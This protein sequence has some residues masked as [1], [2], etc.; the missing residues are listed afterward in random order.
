MIG[1]LAVAFIISDNI[2]SYPFLHQLG[3]QFLGVL[4]CAIWAFGVTGAILYGVNKIYV[5]RIGKK[6]ER[7]GLNIEEHGEYSEVRDLLLDMAYH[8]KSGHYRP[9]L[10]KESYGEIGQIRAQYNKVLNRVW[11][12]QKK[13]SD[14]SQTLKK[15]RDSLELRVEQRTQELSLSNEAPRGS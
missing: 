8:E 12:E 5:F 11:E 10:E 15:E 4:V 7:V 13:S 1:T 6:G 14:L 3:V 2:F 9:V